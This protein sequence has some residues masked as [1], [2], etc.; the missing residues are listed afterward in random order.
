M[1]PGKQ[2]GIRDW[3]KASGIEPTVRVGIVLDED[4][5]TTV[6]LKIPASP[7]SLNGSN[8]EQ[9]QITNASASARLIEGKIALTIADEAEQVDTI[10]RFVPQKIQTSLRGEGLLVHDVVAGRGFHWFKQIDQTFCGTIELRAGKN[11][12]ILINELPLEHYLMGVITAEM[13]GNCPANLLKTQCVVARSWLLAL[14]EPKHDDDPF[15]RC[16][17]DCCQRYQG[18]GDL[19]PAAADAV[20][21]TRSLTLIAPD[22]SVVDAN[23]SKSCGGVAELP[24]SVWGIT[25]PGLTALFD[26]PTDSPDKRF[27][28]RNRRKLGRLPQRYLATGY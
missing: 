9:T 14:T 13:S 28:P 26:G 11:G 5:L 1:E 22:D 15:D 10:W 24:E 17:D 20:L 4:A 16:N 25:K 21:S 27:F 7:Y 8:E 6:Q 19:S 12:I 2:V 18:T 23:Y 3:T